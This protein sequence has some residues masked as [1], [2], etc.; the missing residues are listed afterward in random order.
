MRRGAASYW[1]RFFLTSM[2]IALAVMIVMA[3]AITSS[4]RGTVVRQSRDALRQ[5]A[6]LIATAVQIQGVPLPSAELDSLV[7]QLG[8]SIRARI[9]VL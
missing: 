6:R 5:Q 7:R 2:A 3:L 9:T 4:A 8:G 1:M